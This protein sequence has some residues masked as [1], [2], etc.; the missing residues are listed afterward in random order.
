[1]A[2]SLNPYDFLIYFSPPSSKNVSD[3]TLDRTLKLLQSR[4]MSFQTVLCSS[5]GTNFKLR[6]L[7]G[8]ILSQIVCLIS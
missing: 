6:D 3:G 1:M 7:Q 8:L 5:V 4:D 2:N